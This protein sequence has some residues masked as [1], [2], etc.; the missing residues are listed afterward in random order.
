MLLSD[1]SN[2]LHGL[3]LIS[4]DFHCYFFFSLIGELRL[5]DKS[6]VILK[7]ELWPKTPLTWWDER[8]EECRLVRVS[9]RRELDFISLCHFQSIYVL[10]SLCY[11]DKRKNVFEVHDQSL[12]RTYIDIFSTMLM[13]ERILQDHL[14]LVGWLLEK[15]K[16]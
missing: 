8:E 13:L 2:L 3:N 9:F 11:V 1:L 10:G 15:K 14:D 6:L 7:S 12:H 16:L 4:P 5:G